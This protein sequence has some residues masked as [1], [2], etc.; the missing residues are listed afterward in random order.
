MSDQMKKR[1]ALV[2]APIAS[3]GFVFA[4][5]TIS[6]AS[7]TSDVGTLGSSATVVT[8]PQC[9]WNLTNLSDTIALEHPGSGTY[10]DTH[11]KYVGLDFGLTGTSSNTVTALVGASGSNAA[12]TSDADN[13]S[14]YGTVKQSS[15]TI[16]LT[17]T[18][19]T[20]TS[21]SNGSDTSM[22]FNVDGS[23]TSGS[24][25]KSL[26]FNLATAASCWN[27]AVGATGTDWQKVTT[28]T[29]ATGGTTSFI[30]LA[31]ATN[32]TTTSST[33]GYTT[34]LST[35]IPGGI[36]PLHPNDSYL[37]AGPALTTTLSIS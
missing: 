13:C 20:G 14:W 21:T 15:V 23:S 7:A 17:G 22:S 33:C 30:P 3:V 8:V 36:T 31:L 11:P 4:L 24:H 9:T 25:T 29:L 28:S 1:L 19:F 32:K 6:S 27:S 2:M 10:G 26:I 18:A 12:S 37:Y 16:A 35:W 5:S 34:T